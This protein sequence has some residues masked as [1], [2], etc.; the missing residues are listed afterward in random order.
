MEVLLPTDYQ[1]RKNTSKKTFYPNKKERVLGSR[2]LARYVGPHQLP[3]NGSD[4]SSRVK[5]TET[6]TQGTIDGGKLKKMKKQITEVRFKHGQ[7]LNNIP[8]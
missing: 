6:E 7:P 5:D 3:F 2:L 4:L 8:M 1:E